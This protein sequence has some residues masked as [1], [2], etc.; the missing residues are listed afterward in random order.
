MGE[1]VHWETDPKVDPTDFLT[2]DPS[3]DLTHDLDHDRNHRPEERLLVLTVNKPDRLDRF[4]SSDYPDFSRSYW[5]K[6]I[7]S[8]AVQINDRVCLDKNYVL[9][10][11]TE[12]K[13]S[14]PTNQPLEIN[15][16]AIPL[17]ILWEDEHL[18]VV[19]KPAGM[20][21]HP[22][23]GHS[24]GTLVNALLAHCDRLSGINGV[25]RPGIVHR[26]DRD[27]S[28]VMVVA[29]SDR[30]HQSLQ[31]QIQ[32]KT[33]RRS[34]LGLVHGIPKTTAGEISAPIGRHPIDRQKMAVIANGRN[35][36]THWRLLAGL[37]RH[38]LLQFDLATGRTHQ[39]RV[40]CLHMGYPIVNDP[41]YGQGRTEAK[42]PL[43]GQ[44][45]HS[46]H[47]TF[48]HPVSGQEMHHTAPMPKG[49]EKLLHRWG[50]TAFDCSK[51]PAPI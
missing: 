9:K 12:I 45:L 7:S 40:H 51:I 25:E 36:L 23:P 48:M 11:G 38:A 15:P 35:A 8:G 24:S 50:L 26:L 19:N 17:D 44:A 4:L 28:G 10:A 47:L 5:Q 30:A 20:V 42:F 6:L 3:T 49:F 1:I 29:K 41:I 16:E 2:S 39:I 32:A 21:V 34:Y 33:A 22:A 27:T 14:L 31:S 37:D 13:V 46:W 43:V 18:V